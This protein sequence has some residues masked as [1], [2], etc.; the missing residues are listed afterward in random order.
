MTDKEFLIE[1]LNNMNDNR[2]AIIF[3]TPE[4]VPTVTPQKPKIRKYDKRKITHNTLF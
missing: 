4:Q 3:P 2:S 1:L